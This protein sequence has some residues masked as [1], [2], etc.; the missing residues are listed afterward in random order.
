MV[1]FIL[2]VIVFFLVMRVIMR[3][4]KFGLRFFITGNAKHSGSSP[5][6]FSS[7]QGVEEADYEVI[8][9]HLNDKELHVGK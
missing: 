7:R 6:S 2:L 1:R 8:E 4:L 3:V 9:S 5:A